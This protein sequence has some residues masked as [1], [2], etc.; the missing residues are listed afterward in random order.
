M[1]G[2]IENAGDSLSTPVKPGLRRHPFAFAPQ[3]G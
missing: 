2:V 3:T 1:S